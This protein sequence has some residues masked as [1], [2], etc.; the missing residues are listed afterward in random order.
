V[1]QSR[2][3]AKVALVEVRQF[4]INLGREDAFVAEPG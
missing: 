2:A 1:Q 3:Q 4:G